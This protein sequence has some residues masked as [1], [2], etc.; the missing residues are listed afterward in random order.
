GVLADRLPKR[1]VIAWAQT[2]NCVATLVM[3]G[4]IFNGN[5]EFW[6]FIWFGVFN[7]TVLAL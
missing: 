5:V 3:A 1:R 6:D 7:G 2:L 4:I